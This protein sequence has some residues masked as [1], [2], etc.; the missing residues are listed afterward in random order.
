MTTPDSDQTLKADTD[1]RLARRSSADGQFTPGTLVAERYRI[2]S[3]LGKGGMGE[4]Y[5]ADDIKLGQIVALK[6]LP[7]KRAL[8]AKLLDR[9]HD[10]VRLGRQVTHPNVCRI[11]DIGEWGDAHFVAMEYVD[12]E[13]LSRLLHRIGRLPHDKA[14][15]ITR[16]IAAGLAA[17]HA[18]G[19]L[20]RDL[21]PANVMLDS[22]GD[23]RITDFGLALTADD[24]QDDVAGTPAYMAPELLDGASATIQ[25]DLYALGLVMY[26]IFTGKRPYSGRS[27]QELRREQSS[28]ITTPSNVIRDIE[29]AVERIILRCLSRDPA[30]RPR[31]ARDVIAALP[32]GDPLAAALAAGETPSPKLIAAAGSEGTLSPR[33]AWSLLGGAVVLGVLLFLARGTRAVSDFMRLDRSPQ[34]L[35]DRG[36]AILRDLGVPFKGEPL[37]GFREDEIYLA[38][39]ITNPGEGREKFKPMRTGPPA[40]MYRLEYGVPQVEREIEPLMA[41]APGRTT[42]EVDTAGRLAFLHAAPADEWKARPLDWSGLLAAAGLDPARLRS[43]PPTAAPPAP[44]DARAAWSGTYPADAL[45]IRVEAAAWH[46]TPVFFK[47]TGEWENASDRLEKVPFS[48]RLL[49]VFMLTVVVILSTAAGV[50][51]WRNLRLRRGDRQ[52]ALRIAGVIVALELARGLLTATWP[53]DFGAFALGGADPRGRAFVG[54]A[55]LSRLHRPRAV[56]APALAPPADRVV[57]HAVGPSS[58]SDGR[59]RHAHRPRRGTR[60]CT[61][62]VGGH[63]GDGRDLRTQ[64]RAVDRQFP[65]AHRAGAFAG[66]T[67]PVRRG[68]HQLGAHRNRAARHPRHPAQKTHARDRRVLRDL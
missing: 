15:D 10:E 42:V 62:R 28:E 37:R 61:A 60:A 16:G 7:A 32:G 45:P 2:S 31:S 59:A 21:K 18:K 65:H 5:R 25:S 33:A 47:I 64:L 55:H 40:M 29:P 48:G 63:G 51:A 9:L 39:L 43:V 54:S 17:A 41:T 6:F 3:I 14:V 38:W 13:D 34:V 44:F 11:Y 30:Q 20:H 19:I 53:R 52:G 4:V 49:D 8:D 67:P 26:E 22:H 57:A 50:L 27:L 56:C 68:R 12:G 36:E 23:A 58:R 35:Q 66:G 24:D 1:A 46:G